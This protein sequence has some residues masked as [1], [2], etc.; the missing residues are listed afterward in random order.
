MWWVV[1]LLVFGWVM[2]CQLPV[3]GTSGSYV[4][5]R[6]LAWVVLLLGVMD[7]WSLEWRRELEVA[8]CWGIGPTCVE[9]LRCEVSTRAP[10][11][12]DASLPVL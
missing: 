4:S 11:I 2:K 7:G 12:S 3:V 1:G 8:A 6:L 9:F 5:V 10:R